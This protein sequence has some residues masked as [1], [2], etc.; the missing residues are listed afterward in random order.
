MERANDSAISSE[1]QAGSRRAWALG[2]IAVWLV[3][4]L[5]S[6]SQ[7]YADSLQTSS[8]V[9][10]SVFL[11]WSLAIWS[12]WALLTPL[13]FR[14]GERLPL[15]RERRVLATLA[16]FAFSLLFGLSHIALFAFLGM[17]L[18]QSR[19]GVTPTFVG[20]FGRGLRVFLYLELIIYWA[21][22]GAAVARDSFRKYREREA[23]ARE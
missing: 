17:R 1:K 21:I 10:F 7:R 18:S 5:I 13:V 11:L 8:P 15:G 4:S 19:P 12:Y 9:G 3:L 2:V 22:L 16:H 20:E 6:A 23:R 14:L